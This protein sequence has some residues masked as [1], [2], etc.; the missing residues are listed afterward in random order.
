MHNIFAPFFKL[1]NAGSKITE[2]LAWLDK[3]KIEN[4][5]NVAHCELKIPTSIFY[6]IMMYVNT[7]YYVLTK[8]FVHY[9]YLTP[10]LSIK[11]SI[12]Y[13]LLLGVVVIYGQGS[14]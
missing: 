12:K 2:N 11:C 10:T 1:K 5:E 3:W 4:S 13:K 8:L 7:K 6:Q 9:L 14:L